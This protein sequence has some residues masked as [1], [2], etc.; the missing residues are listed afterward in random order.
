MLRKLI[1]LALCM[2]LCV[3]AAVIP[4]CAEETAPV[5]KRIT[6]IQKAVEEGGD[7]ALW[8]LVNTHYSTNTYVEEGCAD[9]YIWA[10]GGPALS[11]QL[12]DDYPLINRAT[13]AFQET[14]GIGITLDQIFSYVI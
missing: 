13:I 12:K 6:K 7:K 8:E 10:P 3:S 1:S 9:V 4:A 11:E 5:E 2:I 14:A